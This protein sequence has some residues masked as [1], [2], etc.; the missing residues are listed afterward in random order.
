MLKAIENL[1]KY[2]SVNDKVAVAVSGGS[3]SMCL[4]HLVLNCGFIDKSNILVVNVNH[5]IR[6][7]SSAQ[8]SL[9]VESFCKQIGAK[10]EGYCVDVPA[11]CILSGCSV[12]QEARNARI[13]IFG[14]IIK[15]G[16]ASKVLVAHHR[17]DQAESILLHIAR[18]C[19]IKGICGMKIL[20]D[21]WLFRPLL[22][23]EKKEITDYIKTN[24]VPFVTDESN[25]ND[26]YDRNFIRLNIMPLLKK[27]WDRIENSFANLA[28][29]AR[30][31]EDFIAGLVR[32]ANIT[33]G[34][35]YVSI[36]I[37]ALENFSLAVRYF[38]K[39]MSDLGVNCDIES[40]HYRLLFDLVKKG[41]NGKRLN[42]KNG[43]SA[44]RE[45]DKITFY[46]GN[47]NETIEHNFIV[48]FGVGAF[49]FGQGKIIVAECEN[50]VEKGK[51]RL[52]LDAIPKGAEF[53]RRED[54]DMF[55][56]YNSKNKKLKQYLID[57][58]IPVRI[59]DNI[60]YLCYNNKILSVVG[61]EI[62]D[63]V[64]L[65]DKTKRA[66]EIKFEGDNL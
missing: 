30:Q 35:S 43:L 58:K 50:K 10:F 28:E 61:Y 27:R 40:K 24:E 23:T 63:N 33:K 57:K 46:L 26:D 45:Y 2:L 14:D 37:S 22:D 21:G 52:D 36:D 53:R 39:V 47:L 4:L 17:A 7:K 1:K 5:N 29:N 3:D 49:V 8:D 15:L 65:T 59:R 34:Q 16:R 51:L 42:I 54:G 60:P 55:I 31:D 48:P 41:Q 44:V 62:A 64:K 25:L 19:G 66:V 18:G 56:P 13:G 38:S 32:E 20:T 9:F 6:G 11:S 12:E